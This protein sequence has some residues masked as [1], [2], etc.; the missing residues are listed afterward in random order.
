M[1]LYYTGLFQGPVGAF[2]LNGFQTLG[3]DLDFDEFVQ[4]RHKDPF[5][6]QVSLASTFAGRVELG[7]PDSVGVAASD[8]GTLLGNGAGFGHNKYLV[9]AVSR[10]LSL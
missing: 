8:L 5:F 6:L 2:F 7:S 1:D 10:D 9:S 4:L 3:R